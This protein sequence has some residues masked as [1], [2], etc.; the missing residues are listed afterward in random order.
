MQVV[1]AARVAINLYVHHDRI[2][3]L[4]LSD[5]AQLNVIAEAGGKVGAEGVAAEVAGRHAGQK[6]ENGR[7]AQQNH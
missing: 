1:Q 5:P 6:K 7:C 4:N 3:L 2:G